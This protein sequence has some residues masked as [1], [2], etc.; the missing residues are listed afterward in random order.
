VDVLE[1]AK[2]FDDHSGKLVNHIIDGS[3]FVTR[4]NDL[5]VAHLKF[6]LREVLANRVNP[7]SVICHVEC[8]FPHG[9][10]VTGATILSYRKF[11]LSRF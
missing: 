3:E 11:P 9:N 8:W 6:L 2:E 4:I 1:F 5:R 7:L 10:E